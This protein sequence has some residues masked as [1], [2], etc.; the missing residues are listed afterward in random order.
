MIV[1][2]PEKAIIAELYIQANT[3]FS[4]VKRFEFITLTACTVGTFEAIEMY[5]A[6]E[7]VVLYEINTRFAEIWIIPKTLVAAVH[8]IVVVLCCVIVVPDTV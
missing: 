2:K 7:E 5:R 4:P 8:V 1:A 6:T 3:N